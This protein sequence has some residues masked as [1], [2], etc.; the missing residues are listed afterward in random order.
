MYNILAKSHKEV[1]IDCV[2]MLESQS[3][4][5]SV[6]L[7]LFVRYCLHTVYMFLNTIGSQV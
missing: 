6:K 7:L 3:Y 5:H 2:P 1:N 4:R